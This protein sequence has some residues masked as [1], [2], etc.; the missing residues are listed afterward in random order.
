MPMQVRGEYVSTMEKQTNMNLI[1]LVLPASQRCLGYIQGA[2]AITSSI[3][4][5]YQIN[6]HIRILKLEQEDDQQQQKA[7]SPDM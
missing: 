5:T 2:K 6:E 1:A 3:L 4:Q 7:G